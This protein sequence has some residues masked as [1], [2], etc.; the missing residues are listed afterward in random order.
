[1]GAHWTLWPRGVRRTR[2]GREGRRWLPHPLWRL[3]QRAMAHHDRRPGHRVHRLPVHD[4]RWHRL[5]VPRR[6]R[7]AIS[8]R[9]DKDWQ[10]YVHR[11]R[12][13]HHARGGDWRALHRWRWISPT[14]TSAGA[15][16]PNGPPKRRCEV[17][18]NES[19]WTAFWTP[20][21]CRLGT[22]TAR[23]IPLLYRPFEGGW[24]QPLRR[25]CRTGRG[26]VAAVATRATRGR[27]T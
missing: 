10:R 13:Q 23:P 17:S 5:A 24:Q 4:P 27:K 8:V 20:T 11:R 9:P 7:A 14:R 25:I 19:A 3:Q 21:L 12:D 15:C 6:T 16:W 2:A 26:P 22:S 1:L 18:G